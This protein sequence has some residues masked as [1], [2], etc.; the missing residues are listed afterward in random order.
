[1]A[2]ASPLNHDNNQ[3][4]TRV[5]DPCSNLAFINI[6]T[7]IIQIHLGSTFNYVMLYSHCQCYNIVKICWLYINSGEYMM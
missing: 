4:G 6:S 3:G 2:H 1:M 7:S 5:E